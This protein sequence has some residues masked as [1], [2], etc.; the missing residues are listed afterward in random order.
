MELV[1]IETPEE[2]SWIYDM[3]QKITFDG[4]Y[5]IWTGALHNSTAGT[6][7]WRD[8]TPVTCS[9][10]APAE[11]SGHACVSGRFVP[12]DIQWDAH[13]CDTAYPYVCEIPDTPTAQTFTPAGN[14]P[15]TIKDFAL[16][17]T[18]VGPG[19]KV[20]NDFIDG[21]FVFPNSTDWTYFGDIEL[22]PI[23]DCTL[24]CLETPGCNHVTYFDDFTCRLY[25]L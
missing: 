23:E 19:G 18:R 24:M 9:V 13:R 25:G 8:E 4:G 12:G 3:V 21:R 6:Y 17:D 22:S 10:W 2:N 15:K 7:M 11:P 14:C 5:Y 20:Q 1:K 16:S